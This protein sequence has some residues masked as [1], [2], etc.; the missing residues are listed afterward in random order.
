MRLTSQLSEETLLQELGARLARRRLDLE[1]AQSELAARAGVS[2]RTIE[3]IEAGAS[4]QLGNWLRVLRALEL[5]EGLEAVLPPVE[6]RPMDL[7]Q[8]QRKQRQRVSRTR[9]EEE[10]PWTWGDE[11]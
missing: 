1:L 6:P 3:R 10:E 7:L 2:K 8:L 11:A 9:G 4:T 5:V